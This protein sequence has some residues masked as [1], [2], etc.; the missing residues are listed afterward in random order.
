MCPLRSN[1]F[2]F[3]EGFITPESS[4]VVFTDGFVVFIT[5]AET[6]IGGVSIW[7]DNIILA[8][9]GTVGELFRFEISHKAFEYEFE[10]IKFLMEIDFPFLLL[11]LQ[12]GKLLLCFHKFLFQSFIVRVGD[13]DK[14]F[15]MLNLI[16]KFLIDHF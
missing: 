5:K 7:H 10:I 4:T 14:L 2:S 8:S 3:L 15:D 9:L 16:W 11:E 1:I 13:V 12:N 6:V